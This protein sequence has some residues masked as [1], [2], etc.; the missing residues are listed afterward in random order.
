MRNI[1][2]SLKVGIRPKEIIDEFGVDSGALDFHL[3]RLLSV[4]LI[5]LK[6]GC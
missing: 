2:F 1:G 6:F 4:G 5:V 3:K